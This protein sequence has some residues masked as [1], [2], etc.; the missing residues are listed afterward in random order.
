MVVQSAPASTCSSRQVTRELCARLAWNPDHVD[1][2]V[3]VRLDVF[4]LRAAH[5][6]GPADDEGRPFG[7][8]GAFFSNAGL[9]QLRSMLVTV[10]HDVEAELLE[11]AFKNSCISYD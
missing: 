3:L 10:Q 5:A 7:F 4:Q 8:L 6:P 11:F 9:S 2:L 1:A